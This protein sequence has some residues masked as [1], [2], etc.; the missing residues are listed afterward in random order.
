MRRQPLAD[1]SLTVFGLGHMRPAPGT[2][3]SMP[4][5]AMAWLL[6]LA[7]A[8]DVAY[9][10][11]LAAAALISCGACVWFGRY[12]EQRFN[13][14]DPSQVVADEC[15]GQSI[16]LALLP[17]LA[18]GDPVRATALV[19]GAFLLFRLMDIVKPFP[20]G[21]LQRLPAGWGI[22]VDDLV[23]GLYALI[24]LQ[25]VASLALR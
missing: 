17:S 8:G 7:G 15:A 13:R 14:K 24:A 6:L 16:A 20:A 4:A 11:F 21:R 5:A 10:A 25:A 9:H 12:A 19:A 18:A 23:A 2:W 1:L 3:G 22:L